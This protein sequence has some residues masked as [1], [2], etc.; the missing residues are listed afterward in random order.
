[1][2]IKWP[3]MLQMTPFL[4]QQCIPMDFIKFQKIFENARKSADF[5]SEN[6][7]FS[8]FDVA[9]FDRRFSERN[10]ISSWENGPIDLNFVLKRT[11]G[12]PPQSYIF[13]F[14]IF[15]LNFSKNCTF[16]TPGGDNF[17]R[18]WPKVA[19]IDPPGSKKCNFPKYWGKK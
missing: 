8:Q 7:H 6:R 18:F 4:D 11:L 13:G 19:K 9:I 14:F 2:A 15:S 16:W 12:C 10:R 1:M 5:W 17:R 3:K